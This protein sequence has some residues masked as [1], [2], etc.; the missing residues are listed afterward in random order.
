MELLQQIR[1]VLRD[2]L[3]IGSRADQLTIDSPLL[4][5]LPEFDSMAVISVTTM[6]EDR[7]GIAIDDDEL[8]AEVF[9]TVGSLCSFLEQK[10]Q[11]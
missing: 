11:A 8:S 1:T 4:G 6:L 5:G 3:Q 10:L 9:A 2:A 7:F